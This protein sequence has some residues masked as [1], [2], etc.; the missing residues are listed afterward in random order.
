MKPE[1]PLSFAENALEYEKLG[2]AE[3]FTVNLILFE[4]NL[5]KAFFLGSC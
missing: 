1:T 4:S 5:A 3:K 2:L